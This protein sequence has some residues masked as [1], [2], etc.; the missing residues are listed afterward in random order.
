M[1]NGLNLSLGNLSR[2]TVAQPCSI[3]PED[4]TGPKGKGGMAIEG[5][6][7]EAARDPGTKW[8]VSPSIKT[9]PG[10][11]LEMANIAGPSTIQ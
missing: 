2:L 11:T 6:R 7:T 3:F 4:L 5:T 1:Y 10:Q 9:D 8:K